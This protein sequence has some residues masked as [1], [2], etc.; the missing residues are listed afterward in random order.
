MTM[1]S[2]AAAAAVSIFALAMLYA[3]FTDVTTRTI[4][5]S[6]VLALALA[7][8]ALAPLAGFAAAEIGWSAAVAL[9]VLLV[10]FVLFAL[11]WFGGGDAKL[12]AVTA[13]WVGAAH[14][15]SY[16]VYTAL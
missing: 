2:L 4:R 15:G 12:A 11:G 6:L 3:G 5:N 13:L 14:T 10:S 9:A 1:S 7:Y 8:A 16:L